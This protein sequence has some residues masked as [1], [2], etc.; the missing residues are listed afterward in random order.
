MEELRNKIKKELETYYHTPAAI[1][2]VALDYLEAA[3]D[4]TLDIVDPSSPFMFLLEASAVNTNAA[5]LKGQ[6]VARSLY[7]LLAVEY[8]DLY[9]HM[10]D[11][12]YLDRFAA[13]SRTVVTLVIRLD[14]FKK[15]AI[16]N[17]TTGVKKL[18]I[19][20]DT[21]FIVGGYYWYTHTPID[22]IMALNGVVQVYYDLNNVSPLIDITTNL[23][24][25]TI[26][27][28]AGVEEIIIRVPVEQL[29]VTTTT[30]PVSSS[31]GLNVTMD[32][33]NYFYYV[34]AYQKF[35]GGEWMEIRVTHSDQVYD[36]SKVTLRAVVLD[37]VLKLQLPEIYITAKNV[38]ESIRVDLYSTQGKINVDLAD[39]A[40]ADFS[41]KW[42]DIGYPKNPYV[43]PLTNINDISIF[44][45]EPVV[46]GRNALSFTELRERVIYRGGDARASIT[47]EE[48]S[49]QLKDRGYAL[50]RSK[51]TVTQRQY[52]CSRALPAPTGGNASTSIGVRHGRVAIDVNRVDATTAIINNGVR[53]TLTDKAIF[54][55]NGSTVVLLS[56]YEVRKLNQLSGGSLATELN[57][58]RYYN[59]P[60]V[61]VMDPADDLYSIRAYH[62]NAPKEVTRSFVSSN[63]DI[64]FTVNTKTVSVY[65]EG[66]VFRIVMLAEKQAGVEGLGGFLIHQDRTGRRTYV[67]GY[68]TYLD[69]KYITVTFEI[70]SSLDIS[71]DNQIE[72]T[73]MIG[74]NNA[75]EKVYVDLTSDFEVYYYKQ[76]DTATAS[77]FD[78]EF[79]SSNLGFR[80]VGVTHERCRIKFGDELHRLAARARALLIP[81]VYLRTSVDVPLLHKKVV[82]ERDANGIPVWTTDPDTNKPIFTVKH[83]V[84]DVVTD[85]N[86]AVVYQSR[87]GDLEYDINGNAVILEEERLIWEIE[88][89]L[90]DARYFYATSS[91]A[92]SYLKSIPDT[93]L[94]YLSQDIDPMIGSM[95]ARTELIFQPTASVGSVPVIVDG[96]AT[97]IMDT[98]L[99]FTVNYMLE[100]G[101][102]EDNA[103]RR[104]LALSTKTIIARALDKPTLAM[105]ELVTMLKNEGG[106]YVVDV[107]VENPIDG[108]NVATVS[109]ENA[110][111]SIKSEI[112]PMS[113][114]VLDIVD[115]VDVTFTRKVTS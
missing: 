62:L 104:N 83:N 59:T 55:D 81:P 24:D 3:T 18:T 19:P 34:R 93:I 45:V 63:T 5:I 96:T 77:M 15:H 17:P 84:G 28:N 107:H 80:V 27:N 36:A 67:N 1:Q 101:A 64:T 22:V 12:D 11:V 50:I 61:Y 58:T 43:I 39:Y 38:G 109:P 2:Q 40:P 85:V 56:D 90:L 13:P 78:S 113:N 95:M 41:G 71:V 68:T 32:F 26:I 97:V 98:A 9:H 47:F 25:Y 53:K 86:G 88:P 16:A 8:G 33:E 29:Q 30:L 69:E 89:L 76:S 4:G 111:F 23:L 6:S 79:D 44:A 106:E 51:D 35:N 75:S 100:A 14:S 52:I 112:V 65:M 115:S 70:E 73:N 108:Y 82:Y 57:N 21:Q 99:Q 20:R 48:L 49:F 103:L 60:F 74:Q 114:G 91:S 94:S 92:M 37:N 105:S 110:K 42:Q 72:F 102:Y 46:G 10:S 7:P 54:K 66:T 87:V 31:T